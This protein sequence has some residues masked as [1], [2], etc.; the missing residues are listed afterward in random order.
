MDIQLTEIELAGDRRGKIAAGIGFILFIVLL[1]IP[2]FF[3]LNPPPGQPGIAVLL[4]FDDAGSGDAPA[5]PASA[6]APAE[7][8][9]VKPPPPTPEIE[10][11]P[12]PVKPPPTPTKPEVQ[13]EREV[14]QQE[15]PAEISIRKRKVQEEA[16]K[17]EADRIRK[18][19][20]ADVRRREEA[21]ATAVREQ[22][23][24]EQRERQAREAAIAEA[25]AKEEAARQRREANAARLRDQLGGGLSDNSGSGSGDSNKPGTQGDPNGVPGGAVTAGSGSGRI[26]GFG[27]RSLVA[28]PAVREKCQASG[29]VVVEVCIAPSGK[30][31]SSK[32]T[33]SGT[34]TQNSC[35]IN[36]AVANSKT[37]KFSPNDLAPAAQCGKITYTFKLQ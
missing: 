5:P 30:V 6:P 23:A 36:S 21:T 15:T 17:Q 16:R 20:E 37:W 3:H 7:P 2:L 1:L 27:N 25:R 35:L 34:T 28:S 26:S 13:P 4:A 22:A 12:E 9:P 11:E 32:K 29:T 8:E 31:V 18:Q 14:I 10:P 19:Q 24:R 33:Q